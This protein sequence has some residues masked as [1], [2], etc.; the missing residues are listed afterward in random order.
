[1]ITYNGHLM[2]FSRCNARIY[3]LVQQKG[4][5][6]GHHPTSS[7]PLHS[8]CGLDTSLLSWPSLQSLSLLFQLLYSHRKCILAA[9]LGDDETIISRMNARAMVQARQIDRRCQ[10]GAIARSWHLEHCRLSLWYATHQARLCR[11]TLA[12]IAAEWIVAWPQ[13]SRY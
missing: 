10:S 2:F 4:R 7:V 12:G 8:L 13:L 11:Q 3:L 6:H 9:L 5:S 1:M